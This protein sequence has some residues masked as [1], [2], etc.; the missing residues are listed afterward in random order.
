MSDRARVKFAWIAF[1]GT[2]LIMV[3]AIALMALSR[4]SGIPRGGDSGWRGEIVFLASFYP[5][6][7]VGG[8]IAIRIP[9]NRIGLIFLAVGFAWGL[10]ELLTTYGE[11]GLIEHPGLPGAAVVT[12]LTSWVPG[13][14]LV[15]T[16]SILLFPDGR[17]PSRR[18]RP[19]A[20][21][22]GIVMT[23]VTLAVAVAPGRLQVG[24]SARFIDNP[25][26]LSWVNFNGP[27]GIV[28]LLVPACIL[29][30]AWSMIVRYR[31]SSGDERLQL[32]WLATAAA[33]IASVYLVA[34]AGSI[35]FS[36]DA[37]APYWVGIVQAVAVLSFC[38]IPIAAG[39]AILR[40]HLYDIDVV[41]N[42]TLVYGSLAA[43]ITGFYIAVVVGIGQVLGS[44]G[45]PNVWLS[46]AATAVVAFA[47]QPVRERVQHIANRL[48]YGKRATPYEVLS[49]FSGRLAA[50]QGLD[51]LAPRM[52]RVLAEGIGARRVDVWVLVDGMFFHEG[53]WPDADADGNSNAGAGQRFGPIPAPPGDLP[54]IDGVTRLV[55][56]R[57]QGELLGAIAV[58][59]P[60]GEA[61]SRVDAA[62]LE[63][64]AAQSGVVLRNIR[65]AEEL[66]AS[67]ARIVAAG[68][69][70]RR[71][72]ERNIHD[73]AQQKLIALSMAAASVRARAK[74]RSEKAAAILGE[75]IEELKAALQEIRELARGIHPSI[76]TNQGLGPALEGLA[77]R[78]SVPVTL[79][80]ELNG[81]APETVEA[82]AYFAVSEALANVAKYAHASRVGVDAAR[83]NGSL[84]VEVTD[85]GI[86][87]ADPEAGSGLRGLLDRVSAVGGRLDVDSPPGRGTTVRVTLPCG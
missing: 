82:T 50:V 67:R 80:T 16:F 24:S 40:Y 87:G 23:I 45:Q 6:V 38:L 54:R 2:S 55:G 49:R 60:P 36:W 3:A 10:S 71:R 34:M 8:L 62:L 57:H 31:R 48:V 59:K 9:R 21:V 35:G 65:L 53:S 44:Q 5:W 83:E 32:K 26:A 56:V 17:L 39:F 7:L 81:R 75:S 25:L 63:D 58:T 47:F 33:V 76:L 20:W 85:D 61:L 42:K 22:C 27:L 77:E 46:I 84:V 52:A 37:G 69:T 79:R 70:E 19:W 72:L 1:A 15:G 41:I 66:R 28:V 18:W 30:S 86:G 64:L 78:S 12:A 73:G 74:E 4:S 51:E 29:G 13:V 14:M 11:F 68:D 43:L